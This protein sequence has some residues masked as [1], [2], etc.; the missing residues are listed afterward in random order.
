[1][2]RR[3]NRAA[4]KAARIIALCFLL[5]LC[6]FAPSVPAAASEAAQE[7]VQPDYFTMLEL[8]DFTV[9]LYYVLDWE[10]GDEKII[11]QL[12]NSSERPVTV[13]GEGFLLSGEIMTD[14]YCYVTTEPGEV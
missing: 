4:G 8:D 11:L 3:E 14:S 7:K 5:F 1:M 9:R 6:P 13:S 10:S 12:R 2:G